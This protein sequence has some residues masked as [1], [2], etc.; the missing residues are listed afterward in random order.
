MS[1]YTVKWKWP[2]E[3]VGENKC[4]W[5][6][7]V[8]VEPR[9]AG[10]LFKEG[11]YWGL[12]FPKGTKIYDSSGFAG[13]DYHVLTL[14]DGHVLV[15]KQCDAPFLPMEICFVAPCGEDDECEVSLQHS[16][17]QEGDES[18][19][20]KWESVPYREKRDDRETKERPKRTGPKR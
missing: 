20:I 4:K 3:R 14:P 9:G 6:Y 13:I 7:I 5:C 2:N 1:E 10:P 18:P 12:D 11:E 15:Y 16:V 19:E 17:I 8:A